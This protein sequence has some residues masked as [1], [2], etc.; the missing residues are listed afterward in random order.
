MWICGLT[1]THI[2][3]PQVGV[4][5]ATELP[6]ARETVP[7]VL[8]LPEL[9]HHPSLLPVWFDLSPGVQ[10]IADSVPPTVGNTQVVTGGS[11]LRGKLS[12]SDQFL[13]V[14][15]RSYASIPGHVPQCR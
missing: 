10:P 8:F 7:R 12:K 3:Y 15:T 6:V 13:L 5:L 2:L 1:H 4:T 14:Y 9:I 11:T